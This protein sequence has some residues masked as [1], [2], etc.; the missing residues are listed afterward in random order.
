MMPIV[1]YSNV[2][3]VK[4]VLRPNACENGG[5]DMQPTSLN[6]FKVAALVFPRRQRATSAHSV[7]TY[8]PRGKK[9]AT[10][11]GFAVSYIHAELDR[12][13]TSIR[14]EQASR[15]SLERLTYPSSPVHCS[16]G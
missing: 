11:T 15:T 10:L 14:C 3:M 2:E 4:I 13:Q 8:L 7:G 6:M 1:Q 12:L 16:K 5:K 9:K